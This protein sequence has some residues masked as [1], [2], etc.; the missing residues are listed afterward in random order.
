MPEGF[1]ILAFLGGLKTAKETLTLILDAPKT[2][3][4]AE[5]EC[6]IAS[7]TK[8]LTE[9]ETQARDFEIM[10]QGKDT[11]IERLKTLLSAKEL[12][13]SDDLPEECISILKILGKRL[14][15]IV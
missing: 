2:L 5:L 1:S 14:V 13:Q 10:I 3:E 12:P 7:L 9:L 11:E 8:T 6:K 4:K 15:E